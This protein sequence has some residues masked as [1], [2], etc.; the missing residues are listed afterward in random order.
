MGIKFDQK[1]CFYVQFF[2]VL[3]NN[4]PVFHWIPTTPD[5]L[6]M[7]YEDECDINLRS[8]CEIKGWDMNDL[9]HLQ[10]S[11]LD[12]MMAES[13]YMWNITTNEVFRGNSRRCIKLSRVACDHGCSIIDFY[14]DYYA[15]D[16]IY[17]DSPAVMDSQGTVHPMEIIK[18]RIRHEEVGTTDEDTEEDSTEDK[19][20]MWKQIICQIPIFIRMISTL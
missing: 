10:H 2:I 6:G 1:C 11:Q 17:E 4:T 15:I 7:P 12:T 9:T 19:K 18:L 16:L 20:L 14:K 5:K 8:F 3:K 13:K